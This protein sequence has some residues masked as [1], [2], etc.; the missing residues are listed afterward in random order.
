MAVESGGLEVEYE[1]YE[2]EPVT[3]YAS[4]KV[5][6]GSERGDCILIS[7]AVETAPEIEVP[8][9]LEVIRTIETYYGP[10]LLLV[11][12]SGQNFKLTA[13][14]P[15]THLLLWTAETNEDGFCEGWNPVAEVV[16]EFG[17][18]MTTY[19]FCDSCGEPIRSIEHERVALI[20]ECN[21]GWD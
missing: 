10:E 18:S 11:G 4:K 19:D 12:H 8:L 14:G 13:P 2:G 16:A 5:M 9:R 3:E 6:V 21:G 1:N 7:E 17:Q 20:G 15:D